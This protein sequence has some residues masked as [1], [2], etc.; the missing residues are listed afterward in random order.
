MTRVERIDLGDGSGLEGTIEA[1]CISM[2]ASGF[3]LASTFVFQTQ[4]VLIFQT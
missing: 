1:L 2:K 3:H 4:L